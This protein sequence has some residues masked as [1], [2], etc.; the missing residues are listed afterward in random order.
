VTF[1]F[2]PQQQIIDREQ[3]AQDPEYKGLRILRCGTDSAAREHYTQKHYKFQHEPGDYTVLNTTLCRKGAKG[4]YRIVALVH[5][6]MKVFREIVKY[7]PSDPP[8]DDYDAQG[9]KEA[10]NRTQSDFKGQKKAN[11]IDFRNYL[12]EGIKGNRTLYLPTVTG[13]QSRKVFD[14]TVFVA[15][16]ESDPNAM[17]GQ[18]YLP[19]APVMQADGQ[20]Q[21]AAIFQASKSVDALEAGALDTMYVSLEIEL[22]V[23][24]LEAGQSFADRNGR[25]SK[26]NK[27]LVISLD[28]S[29]ALSVLRLQ[30]IENTIFE[31]RVG[32]GRNKQTT[33]TATGYIV[34]LSTMEQMLLNV[35]SRG[36][37]KPEH[38]KHHY[39]S[40]FLPYCHEFLK[41]LESS[42]AADWPEQTPDDRD[43]YRRLYVH[44][45][46]FCLKALA[47]VYHEARSDKLGPLAATIGREHEDHDATHSLEQKF[48]HQAALAAKEWKHTPALTFEELKDRL[49]KIDWLR[50][51]RHWIA[52][53][54]YAQA[55]GQKKTFQL[56][57]SGEEKV[58]AKAQNTP[59]IIQTV[60]DKIQSASWV[61]LTAHED[62][63]LK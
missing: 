48:E 54:G 30:A 55:K 42:F 22:G 15:F 33:E 59:A 46:P 37:H 18:L 24:E 35:V 53:T 63:P 29:S 28:T 27:N 12:L 2:L 39:V 6:S 21:T 25:G 34:D 20:T 41:L 17:Y 38:F 50:Y 43:P 57:G 56:K 5:P 3:V 61:D 51:R 19:K 7:D 31:R 13:W 44:G 1:P 9:M 62:E 10:H 8:I 36:R 14:K 60:A 4:R 32:N 49:T 52:L 26:K 11:T 45:W 47:L 58:V 16:D 40:Q 23:N